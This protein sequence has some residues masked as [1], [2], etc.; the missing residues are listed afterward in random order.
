M[1]R[2]QLVLMKKVTVSIFTTLPFRIRHGSSSGELHCR[3]RTGWCCKPSS[4][5]RSLRCRRCS[6]RLSSWRWRC[7]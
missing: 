7:L 4:C 1:D 2:I 5:W 6:R 3:Q